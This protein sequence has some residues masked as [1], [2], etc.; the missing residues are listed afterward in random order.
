MAWAKSVAPKFFRIFEQAL[1]TD[2]IDLIHVV[3]GH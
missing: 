3:L 1:F 2:D